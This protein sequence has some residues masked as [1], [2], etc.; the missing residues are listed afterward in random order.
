MNR[1]HVNKNIEFPAEEGNPFNSMM[2][3]RLIF[4][5]NTSAKREILANSWEEVGHNSEMSSLNADDK[6]N[7]PFAHAFLASTTV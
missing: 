5:W 6:R 7:A 3:S 4:E 2:F 1:F